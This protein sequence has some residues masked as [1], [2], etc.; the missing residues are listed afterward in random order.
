VIWRI[1]RAEQIPFGKRIL[2]RGCQGAAVKELQQ[3]RAAA[4]FYC[5]DQDGCYGVLT[6]EAV[7]LLQQAFKLRRDGLAGPAV[8]AAL[9]RNPVKTGRIIYTVKPGEYLAQISSR[10][11]VLP[12]AWR[13]IPG[14]RPG[15][16]GIYP[17]QRLLLYKKAF[18]IWEEGISVSRADSDPPATGIITVPE[19]SKAMERGVGN[20]LSTVPRYYLSDLTAAGGK[21]GRLSLESCVKLLGQLQKLPNATIGLDLRTEPANTLIFRNDWTKKCLRALGWKQVPFVLLPFIINPRGVRQLCWAQLDWVSR[22]A[23][24][25]MIEPVWEE[26]TADNLQA[27]AR[28]WEKALPQL[29]RFGRRKPLV[30][31]LSTHAWNWDENLTVRRVSLGEAQRIRALYN[32]GLIT[33]LPG[34]W[35]LLSYLCQGRRQE[36]LYRER[37]WWENL[38]QQVVKYNFTGVALRDFG[39]LGED[40]PQLIAAAFSVLPESWL[41]GTES[42]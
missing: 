26:S 28:Q 20:A 7:C 32:Q 24:L 19:A 17:G 42:L 2:Y 10:F 21:S 3:R 29:A 37:K 6:E 36:L 23:R 8:A 18:L 25:I 1:V 33:P 31:A 16:R 40:G 34:R 11:G 5:G 14:N 13:R 30:L 41:W 22:Y 4:G 27:S 38:L 39:A 12:A 9:T 35:A 15:V